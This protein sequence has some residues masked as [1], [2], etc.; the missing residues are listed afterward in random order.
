MKIERRLAAATGC[1][2]EIPQQAAFCGHF[3]GAHGLF[4]RAVF[5]KMSAFRR[6]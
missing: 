5:D 6:Y 3:P 1:A 2:G 4:S